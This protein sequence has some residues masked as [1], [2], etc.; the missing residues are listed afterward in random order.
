MDESFRER[1]STVDEKGKRVWVFPKKPSGKFHNYRVYLS[2]LLLVILF[3][4]PFVKMNGLPIILLNIVERRFV[5]LGVTFWPQD[6][7]LV[8]IGMIAAIVFIVLFTI[9]FGRLFCGWICP[10]TIFMEM[11]FRK[12]EYWI[13]GDY[14]KQKKLANQEWNSEKI[15]KKTAKHIIFF[16]ISF[17]IGNTVLAYIFG[18]EELYKIIEEPLVDHIGLF[19]SMIVFS[20]VFYWIFAWFREQV[21]IIACPYGRLQGVM[22]D[23][24][25]MVVAYDYVR[26]EPRGKLRK[27]ETRTEGDCI[28]CK[29]C[30]HVCPTGIDIRHGTQLECINCTA[31]MDVCD[32]IMDLTGKPKGLI[33]LDSEEGIEKRTGFTFNF[34]VW[35]YIVLLTSMVVLF[36]V[37][38]FSRSSVQATIMRAQGQLYQETENGGISNLYNIDLINKTLTDIPV[39]IKVE[40][41]TATIKMIGNKT[42]VVPNQ[43]S[44]K[45][46]FFIELP[47]NQIDGMTTVLEVGIYDDHGQLLTTQK[48]KF[49]APGI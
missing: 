39:V 1:I 4:A 20:G 44:A 36:F 6:F 23:R 19:S 47:K 8:V 18:V 34:R 26:G 2:I 37:L 29:Q 3:G 5:F 17:L 43:N 9:I 46:L 14:T 13:E 16:A 33:R 21:C 42:F 48:T 11:V 15:L 30:V 41:K 32:D 28:D 25:S 27:N 40:N 24:N 12:I 7:Y 22:L 10:Q 49:I 31:C 45:G 35:S 38:L